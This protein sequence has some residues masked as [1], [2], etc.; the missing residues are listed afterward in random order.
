MVRRND[1]EAG[2]VEIVVASGITLTRD[3]QG[4]REI[5]AKRIERPAFGYGCSEQALVS[6]LL[7]MWA[8]YADRWSLLRFK[9]FGADA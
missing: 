5:S 4:A 1:P 9:R 6:G 7:A 2:G 8:G 3:C